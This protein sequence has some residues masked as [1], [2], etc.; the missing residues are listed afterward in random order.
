MQISL[1]DKEINLLAPSD[2]KEAAFAFQ[3]SNQS[4]NYKVAVYAID[5]CNTQSPSQIFMGTVAIKQGI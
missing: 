1:D 2:A 4:A 3:S 5:Y